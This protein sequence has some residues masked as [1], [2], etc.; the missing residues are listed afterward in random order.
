MK[1][2]KGSDC[3][4]RAFRCLQQEGWQSSFCL[5]RRYHV[6]YVKVS[7]FLKHEIQILPTKSV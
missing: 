2:V 6:A 4:F 5:A 3:P 1:H 7:A